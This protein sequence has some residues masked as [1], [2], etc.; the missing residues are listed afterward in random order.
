P[1]PPLPSPD[2]IT[3]CR[4]ARSW[5]ISGEAGMAS[6][7]TRLK[8]SIATAILCFTG[9]IAQALEWRDLNRLADWSGYDHA[10]SQGAQPKPEFCQKNR[11]GNVAVCWEN[12]QTGEC[13]NA[14]AW[15][16][17]KD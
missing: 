3:A 7:E 13:S 5:N 15:C 12:R 2:R 9:G 11:T 17:Y 16:T 1:P 4:A 8:L 10:C 6:L 14:T